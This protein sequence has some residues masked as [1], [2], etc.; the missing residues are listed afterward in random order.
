MDDDSK[1]LYDALRVGLFIFVE[2]EFQFNE[3][4]DEAKAHVLID[5]A[6]MDE[7]DRRALLDSIPDEIPGKAELQAYANADSWISETNWSKMPQDD[8]ERILVDRPEVMKL[9]QAVPNTLWS[10]EYQNIFMRYGIGVVIHDV[11]KPLFRKVIRSAPRYLP[12]RI[13]RAYTAE[14]WRSIVQ[15]FE[16][17]GTMGKSAVVVLDNMVDE[18]RHAEQMI[19]DFKTYSENAC[20][21]IYATIF[22][23]ATRATIGESCETPNLYI[24][25]ANKTE[26]LAGV[27]KNVARAAINLLIQRYKN[28]CRTAI[29]KSCD[30]LAKNPDLVEYLY[31][32]A[33]AEGEPGYELLQQ[34]ILFMANNDIEQSDEMLQ[35][36]KLSGSLDAYKSSANYDMNVP[37]EL[38]DAAHSENFL[39]AVNKFCTATAPGDIFSYKDHLYIMVGQDCDYM[40]GE[41]RRRRA[42][43][44]EFVSAECIAQSDIEK[45]SDDEKFVYV[46]NYKDDDGN[47]YVLKINYRT[48]RVICNEIVNLC[49]FNQEGRC[50]LDCETELSADISAL[51]QPYMLTYY[52]ELCEY[53]KQVKAVKTEVPD[54]F[55]KANALKVVEP[56]IDLSNYLEQGNILDYGIKRVSRLKK[57][58]SLYL[59]KM[60]LEY[61]GRVPY[62]SI[63]LTGYSIV[64]V[65]IKG[66][67]K[68]VQ[69][70][71]YIKLTN[72]REKNSRDYMRLTWRISNK[73]LQE[74]VDELLG[75][76]YELKD[77][78]DYIELRGKG[79]TRLRC[80]R[81][82]LILRK[83]LQDGLYFIELG[84]PE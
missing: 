75:S 1:R 37:E 55:E 46:N 20:C 9:Y 81:G 79:E 69:A 13:Y 67:E 83:Q 66:A 49:S 64:T 16:V 82:A 51:L 61:R 38:I 35:L 8:V 78:T 53:F 63:N 5:F 30:T 70:T 50:M 59:H 36:I 10:G 31:G 56:L 60:F 74:A 4:E 27:H 15:D 11:F 47:T 17:C 72:R 44:C 22:S 21:P 58:A 12:V 24:G 25:Y 84:L 29:D 80:E 45:L 32:M 52:K 48:R 76:G 41:G 28:K 33:R 7:E 54:F 14:I 23:T 57:T 65:T 6:R 68:N 19:E 77:E 3:K 40:M 26:Q 18:N 71:M 43:L 34:W 62:T 2:D 73:A 42:P 39:P